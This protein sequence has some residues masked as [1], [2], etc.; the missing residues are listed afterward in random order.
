[1]QNKSALVL[2]QLYDQYLAE[3]KRGHDEIMRKPCNDIPPFSFH[4]VLRWFR[5]GEARDVAYSVSSLEFLM[6]TQREVPLVL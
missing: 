6:Q 1:M 2:K 3:G 4:L 5:S